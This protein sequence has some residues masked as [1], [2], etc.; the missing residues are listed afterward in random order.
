MG[1]RTLLPQAAWLYGQAK[2][3]G[4]SR[5]HQA[6]TLSAALAEGHC[7]PYIAKLVIDTPDRQ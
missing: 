2:L 7:K 1:S 4:P 5:L 3:G 6:S